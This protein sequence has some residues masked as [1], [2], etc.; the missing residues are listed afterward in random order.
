MSAATA[1]E[2]LFTVHLRPL[3]DRLDAEAVLTSATAIADT[4]TVLSDPRLEGARQVAIYAAPCQ[5]CLVAWPDGSVGF[6]FLHAGQGIAVALTV[7]Y[8]TARAALEAFH[9]EHTPAAAPAWSH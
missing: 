3:V 8:D 4:P 1:P 2:A 5:Q 6:V 7:A 9:L